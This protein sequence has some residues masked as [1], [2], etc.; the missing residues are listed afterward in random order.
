R[1]HPA[2][3]IRALHLLRNTS[4]SR[5]HVTRPVARQ[6][7]RMRTRSLLPTEA[8]KKQPTPRRILS[9]YR[10]SQPRRRLGE[11]RVGRLSERPPL[12]R[13]A[14]VFSLMVQ[15]GGRRVQRRR[16]PNGLS[17]ALLR[18]ATGGQMNRFT[19]EAP[20]RGAWALGHR[21]DQH[22]LA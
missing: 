18:V 14:A 6:R 10:P 8:Q 11:R 7:I 1:L 2:P 9:T 22:H 3:R 12:P 21:E 4:L 17:N 13:L 15:L 5:K 16:L 19:R 20:G